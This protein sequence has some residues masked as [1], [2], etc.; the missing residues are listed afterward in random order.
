MLHLA[1]FASLQQFV[2]CL[3]SQSVLGLF[4]GNM[5]LQQD[6]DNALIFSRLLLYFPK[7]LQRVYGLY[8]RHV[9]GYVFHLVRLQMTDEMPRYVLGQRLVFLAQFLLMALAEDALPFFV[10]SLYELVGMILT[11]SHKA[12]TLW[13]I[14]KHLSEISLDVVHQP[15][16]SGLSSCCAFLAYS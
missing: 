1:P 12:H 5:Q 14:S 2:Q 9:W 8:H 10:C 3:G 6:I 15:S 13:Q 4:L 16:N 7:Q 11:N